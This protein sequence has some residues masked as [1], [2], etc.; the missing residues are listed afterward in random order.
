MTGSSP[1]PLRV[2]LAGA[3]PWAA[4]VYAPMLAAGP[5][6]TLAGVWARRGDA[7]AALAHEHGA[8]AVATFEALLERCDAIAFAVPPDVQVRLATMA[9]MAGRHLMLDKPV[10][11][12]ASG[13]RRL[14]RAADRAGVVSQLM[15]THRYREATDAFLAEA[16]ALSPMGARFAFLC[17][18]FVDGP[19]ACA[20]RK[21]HGAI[22]DLGPHAFDLLEAVLGPIVD[23]TGRGDPRRW[24][25]LACTH[26]SGA[27]SEC[28]LSG[29]LPT[30]PAVCRMEVYGP[31]GALT[32]DAIAASQAEAPWARVRR[33]FADAVHER[34]SSALDVHRGVQIQETI[35]RALRA[36]A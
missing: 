33:T 8:E 32:F 19:Y 13:A 11:L 16:R 28:S 24:V 7:A 20:W 26:A 2:G 1:A 5:E 30:P 23:V 35:E 6:T 27:V 25:T 22:H 29:A 31:G 15:L 21:Q 12:D 4:K 36:I 18:A 10:A 9:A 14:A 34:R 3:G 17:G